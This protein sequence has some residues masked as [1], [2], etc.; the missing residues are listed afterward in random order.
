MEVSKLHHMES[1]PVPILPNLNA[2][3]VHFEF[4]SSQ[5]TKSQALLPLYPNPLYFWLSF[6]LT[7]GRSCTQGVWA[8]QEGLED[9]RKLLACRYPNLNLSFNASMVIRDKMPSQ[10]YWF[11]KTP[12]M[13][14]AKP[15]KGLEVRTAPS[16]LA[17]WPRT[18]QRKNEEG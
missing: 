2:A 5:I 18:L 12:I 16:E 15:Q 9:R 13:V 6:S 11:C 7:W 4:A 14:H 8:G 17:M 1:Y 10:P 3:G